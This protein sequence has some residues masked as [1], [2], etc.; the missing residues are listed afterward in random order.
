MGAVQGLLEKAAGPGT[1]AE[2]WTPSSVRVRCSAV[3]DVPYAVRCGVTCGEAG[4]RVW[5]VTGGN[6]LRPASVSI[7]MFV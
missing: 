4:G 1:L 6:R 2:L 3:R 5:C 7:R